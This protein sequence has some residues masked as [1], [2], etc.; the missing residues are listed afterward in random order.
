MVVALTRAQ[1][2][3]RERKDTIERELRR[4]QELVAE[5]ERAAARFDELAAA[6]RSERAQ[7]AAQEAA[8]M[9]AEQ[10]D[11][12]AL[13]LIETERRHA[14][15]AEQRRA[16]ADLHRENLQPLE[17]DLTNALYARKLAATDELVRKHDATLRAFTDALEAAAIAADN[18]R[19]VRERLETKL[20]ELE[21]ELATLPDPDRAE[22]PEQQA[23][24][25]LPV[26]RDLISPED[27]L[28]RVVRGSRPVILVDRERPQG[29]LDRVVVSDE[30]EP[31]IAL[32]ADAAR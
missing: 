4:Q 19:A 7:L 17:V 18:V 6:A 1:R 11:A 32:L 9:S 2:A 8:G 28:N 12:R 10:V 3:E 31:L 13:E 5:A 24:L 23:E 22:R 27:P 20:D 16:V 25:D 14:S 21:Q 26:R 29:L 30:L 15:A